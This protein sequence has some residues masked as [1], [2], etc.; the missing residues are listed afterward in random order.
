MKRIVLSEKLDWRESEIMK[1]QVDVRLTG[2][3]DVEVPDGTDLE[4]M[5]PGEYS[6]FIGDLIDWKEA[7]NLLDAE[8]EPV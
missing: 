8:I 7:L 5:E 2:L 3:I 1:E 4:S 6:D